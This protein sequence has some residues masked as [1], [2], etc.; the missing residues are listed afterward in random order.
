MSLL[1]A[2]PAEIATFHSEL[3][4]L[5]SEKEQRSLIK[6]F[7]LASGGRALLGVFLFCLPQM[8]HAPCMKRWLHL[9]WRNH[10][11]DSFS[12]RIAQEWSSCRRTSAMA[13]EVQQPA[14]NSSVLEPSISVE[15]V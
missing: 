3:E 13:A 12:M 1:K 6:K 9:T 10:A 8:K 7:L 11:A 14:C 2:Q 4:Q 5:K 15:S